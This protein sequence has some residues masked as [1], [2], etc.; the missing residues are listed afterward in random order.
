LQQRLD[1]RV[2]AESFGVIPVTNGD[3]SIGAQKTR[4]DA[5]QNAINKL[6]LDSLNGEG[7]PKIRAVLEFGP[8]V[9]LFNEP[10]YIHSYAN[11]VGAGQDRTIFKY[12]GQGSAFRLTNDE[13]YVDDSAV[14]LSTAQN[15]CKSV[16]LKNF[17]I[18]V[19][20]LD[21]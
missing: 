16:I 11:I 3:I 4:A 13:N 21:S 9:F 15:Q 20:N 18:V 17:S 6:Y 14:P 12:T 1:E 7:N 10:I 2:N 5:I 8:G 19:D